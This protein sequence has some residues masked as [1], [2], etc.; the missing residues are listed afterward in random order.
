MNPQMKKL[1]MVA[2]ALAALVGGLG[3][4]TFTRAQGWSYF[5]HDPAA[6]VN[7][8]VMRPQFAAWQHSSHRNVATCQ[9]CHMPHDFVGKWYTKA[10]DG[11]NH[12]KAFTL[13]NFH[14]PI[15][16]TEA[17]ERIAL[18]NCVA[19]HR[20]VLSS[21]THLNVKA[22]QEDGAP[23]CTSCHGNVGHRDQGQ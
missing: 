10:R 18:H 13:G 1:V 22:M 2:V 15:Q 7:C 17:D 16:I 3:M 9:D 8:H 5:S 21:T 19:C 20:T 11:W 4:F 14:E 12:S 6:C 23:T